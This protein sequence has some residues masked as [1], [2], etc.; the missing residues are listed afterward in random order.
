MKV[1]LR[2]SD[3]ALLG[4]LDEKEATTG[5]DVSLNSLLLNI[6]AVGKLQID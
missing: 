1:T 4:P 3:V 2:M 5:A 6:V